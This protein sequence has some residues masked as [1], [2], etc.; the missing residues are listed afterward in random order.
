[1]KNYLTLTILLFCS[2]LLTAQ[3][4]DFK[5]KEGGY[6]FSEIGGYGLAPQ[7]SLG[8][9]CVK[10]LS[11]NR[12]LSTKV[13]V[14][15]GAW[16]VSYTIGVPHSVSMNFGKKNVFMETGLNGWL[17]YDSG[18]EDYEGGFCYTL[19]TNIGVNSITPLTPEKNV[20]LRAYINPSYTFGKQS[21]RG[22]FYLGWN[23]YKLS[24]T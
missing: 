8:Y 16:L 17:G 2:T 3:N 1:M 7:L 21:L 14:N 15:T 11:E 20:M 6:I 23:R 9:E 24:D 12:F 5:V 13:G 22:F 4:Q 18:D 19:G 10:P